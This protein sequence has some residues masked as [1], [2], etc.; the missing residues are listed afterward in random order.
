VTLAVDVRSQVGTFHLDARFEVDAGL[1][2]VFG[3]SGAGKTRLL[4]L[5]AG[6]DRPTE[7]RISLGSTVFDDATS[8]IAAP[9]HQRHVGMVFQHPYLLPH[10][11][12]LS[13]VALAVREGN[14][15]ARRAAAERWLDRVDATELAHR[16]PG[17]LSGGQQQR[18]ALAR[19]L[20]GEPRLLLLDEPFSALDLPVRRRLRGLVRDLVDATGVPT[21]FVTHDPDELAALAD[22]VLLADHGTITAVTD[23]EGALRHLGRTG[24]PPTGP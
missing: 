9:P 12:V 13:N 2:V 17:Q 8:G 23:A 4:R 15:P 18:A 6:L 19:A 3:P 11:S 16:R 5:L 10:R 22:R 7:G 1:T 21:L 14:R 24:A 20:A